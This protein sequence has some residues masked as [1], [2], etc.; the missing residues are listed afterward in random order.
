VKKRSTKADPEP[1][2]G[3]TAQ[4]IL[5][6][7]SRALGAP[8]LTVELLPAFTWG[9]NLRS[10]LRVSH[11]DQ[12]RRATYAAANHR[13]EICGGAGHQYR[14]A[15]HERWEFND[16][17]SCQRLVGLVA[18]CP[19]CHEVKHFGRANENGRGPYAKLHL[20]EV[21]D[22][23]ITDADRYLKLVFAL[24]KLRTRKQWQLDMTW[25]EQFGIVLKTQS[26]TTPLRVRSR[27]L[28]L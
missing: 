22:W 15:C 10:A 18:L 2:L 5:E 19:E 6:Q 25:L 9:S 7:T 14:V 4:E 3:E 8:R 13:C 17:Q 23:S 20:C 12:L 28:P 21:N 11:W 24:W 27:R 1:S 26:I 16:A